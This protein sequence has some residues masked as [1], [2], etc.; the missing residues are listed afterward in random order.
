MPGSPPFEL[1]LIVVQFECVEPVPKG[2]LDKESGNRTAS[3]EVFGP[4]KRR[5]VSAANALPY[6]RF[7]DTL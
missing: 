2:Q 3:S 5:V 4:S 7:L 6:A 1:P